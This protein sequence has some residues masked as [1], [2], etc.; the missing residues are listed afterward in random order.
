MIKKLF[1][2]AIFLFLIG[3]VSKNDKDNLASGTSLKQLQSKYEQTVSYY[4]EKIKKNPDNKKLI[5]KLANFCYD[6]RD[7]QRAEKL[8]KSLNDYTAKVFLAKTLVK[9]RQYDQAI[10]IYQKIRD[11]LEDPEAMFLYGQLLEEKNLFPKAI[12]IYGKVKKPYAEKA[13][14]RITS[15]QKKIENIFPENIK[16]LSKQAENF[17][18]GI[19]DEASVILFVDESLEVL[20]NQTFVSTIHVIKQI[21]KER[22]K[23]SAEV[24]IGYDS[25]YE[26]VELEYARTIAKA[27]K[28]IYAGRENIRDV[29]RYLDFPLYSNSRAFIISMPAVD[30]ESYL[31][32]KVKIYSSKLIDK[33]NFNFIYRIWETQPIFKAKFK[34]IVPESKKVNIKFFNQELAKGI[35]LKPDINT[36]LAKITYNWG[37]NKLKPIVDEY[38]MPPIANINPAILVSS[39]SSWQ[40]IYKWWSFLYKD[41]A[42]LNPEIKNFLHNLIKNKKNKFTQAKAIYEFVAKEVRYVAIEYGDSGYEPHSAVDV[43]VNKYGDCKDQAILLVAL[44]KEAGIDAYPVLIPTRRMYPI[45]K[46]FPSIT[47]NHA[48]AAVKVDDNY[49]FM[50]PTSNTTPFGEI[51]L[52]DQNRLVL[53]FLENNYEIVKT[54]VN[55]ENGVVYSMNIN[56]E[57][58][59]KA[60]IKREISPFGYFASGYRGYLKYSHPARIKEDIS[61]KMTDIAPFSQLL[62]YK[63]ENQNDLDKR[64][65]LTY[66]FVADD[67]LNP[68]GS[69]RILGPL[70]QIELRD[71]LVSK[72]EREFPIDFKGIFS[73]TAY[74]EVILPPNLE[75]KYLPKYQSVDNQWFNLEIDYK[76]IG[77]TIKF[78]QKFRVKRRFVEKNDYQLFRRDFKKALYYL[79]SQIILEKESN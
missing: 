8:L 79:R 29:S 43:F 12:Q 77:K 67:F 54:P 35:N 61:E 47:F 65:I 44:L 57:Q 14:K 70:D 66:K 30:I 26:K 72:A 16:K 53:L 20:P 55:K 22:G 4:Q 1:I 40:N 69:Y 73:K 39:F 24:E 7:Y 52:A 36:K 6:F 19:K 3:C 48:I 34:L 45:T 41:K 11:S 33:D 37:F 15:I 17:I 60:K 68:A 18:S 38:N 75:V 32:Y 51:P 42:I 49:I 64:P 76:N 31:E 9:S 13:A 10:E 21:L 63:I 56:I 5:I 2:I 78:Y 28:V 27:G 62:D 25:T 46:D 50:D 74:I 58:N 23:K 71:S 59:Q